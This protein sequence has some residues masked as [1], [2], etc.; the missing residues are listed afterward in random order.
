MQAWEQEYVD[1][2]SVSQSRLRGLAYRPR[3][4]GCPAG[5]APY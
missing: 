3:W 1:Y 4:A 2:V 5:S